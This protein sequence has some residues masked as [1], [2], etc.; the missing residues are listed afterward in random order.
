[1]GP[2][3][4][5]GALAGI[6]NVIANQQEFSAPIS[7]TKLRE[8]MLVSLVLNHYAAYRMQLFLYRKASGHAG[9]KT[10]NLWAGVDQI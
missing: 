2:I 7:D 6:T 8:P 9:L 3:R 5:R 10:L 1:M 4:L